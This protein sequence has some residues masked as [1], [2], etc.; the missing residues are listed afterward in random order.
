MLI[1]YQG[2]III[3]SHDSEFIN[4]VATSTIVFDDSHLEEFVGGYDDWLSQRKQPQQ[5]V[6]IT[7]NNIEQSKNKLAYE[8][9]KQLRNL[10]QIR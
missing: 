6:K 1:N 2:T 7:K 8:Q 3:V 5:P 4:N 9:K 10:P